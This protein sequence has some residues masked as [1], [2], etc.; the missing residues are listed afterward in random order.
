MANV[1]KDLDNSMDDYREA[2]DSA[3]KAASSAEKEA[4]KLRERANDANKETSSDSD[5][6][7]VF[8]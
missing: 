4:A 5:S 7:S 2:R 1:E 3:E 6:K 8:E